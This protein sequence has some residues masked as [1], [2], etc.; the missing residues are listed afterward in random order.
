MK[1]L[2]LSVLTAG[3]LFVMPAFAYAKDTPPVEQTLVREGDYAVEMVKALNINAGQDEA[4]AEN[5]LASLGIAPQTGW[6]S[7]FP[8]TPDIIAQLQASVD[9]AASA[10]RL[11]MGREAA[12][13][14]FIAMNSKLGLAVTPAEEGQYAE[15]TE[16]D[17]ADVDTYYA[18]E[19]PPV[20][21]Y[22][23]PPPDY[24]YLYAWDPYPFWCDGFYF[25]GFFILTDFDVDVGHNHH[26]H[27]HHHDGD[28]DWDNHRVGEKR[29]S[30][31]IV[32]PG[33]GKVVS[34][35]PVSRHPLSKTEFR[36]I[37]AK[38]FE[39]VKRPEGVATRR[40][41]GNAIIRTDGTRF[42]RD[43][44]SR[45]VNRGTGRSSETSA[46]TSNRIEDTRAVGRE[47]PAS[48]CSVGDCSFRGGE[49]RSVR[50]EG[51]SS[52]AVSSGRGGFSGESRG[53]SAGR[54]SGSSSGFS[55]GSR[56]FSGGRSFSSPGGSSGGGFSGGRSMGG[57]FGG[58]SRK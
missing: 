7:D 17:Q 3:L 21:T 41:G 48:M 42:D 54:S 55:G 29:V 22:Y 45:L 2:Y 47:L 43:S 23:S 5:A 39:P 19:G 38:S 32:V 57:G 56:G 10:G 50:G 25:P 28:R 53:S 16:A 33:S 20:L 14:A 40:D 49:A 9:D 13:N 37:G 12:V 31:H 8:V 18:D 35:D 44:A 52:G 4:A 34:L 51:R 15:Q 27:G 58:G 6:I 11:P 36:P 1:R 46:N 24:A 30:N 26:H